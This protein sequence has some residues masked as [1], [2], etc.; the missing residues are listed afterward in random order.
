MCYLRKLPRNGNKGDAYFLIFSFPPL[1][2]SPIKN[3]TCSKREVA[4]VTDHFEVE[5]SKNCVIM[6]CVNI[7]EDFKSGHTYTYNPTCLQ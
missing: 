2:F 6:H 3:C 7:K 4:G 1:S 5:L